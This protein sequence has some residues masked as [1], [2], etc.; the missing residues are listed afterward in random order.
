MEHLAKFMFKNKERW[1]ICNIANVW[2]EIIPQKWCINK[3][4]IPIQIYTRGE[5][6]HK[7][8]IELSY[9]IIE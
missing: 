7:K 8:T 3:E 2:W 5:H 9:W 1:A 4:G 6:I